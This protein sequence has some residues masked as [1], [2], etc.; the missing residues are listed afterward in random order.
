MRILFLT[1]RFPYPPDRGDRLRAY[2]FIERLSRQHHIHLISFISQQFEIEYIKEIKPFCED[3]QTILLPKYRSILHVGTNFWKPLPLQAIY[4]LSRDMKQLVRTNLH[5]I[6][7]DLAYSHLFRMAP[8]LE[9]EQNIYRIVD[10]T[11]VI[12]REITRSMP[13]RNIL[14]NLLYRVELP[15][16]KK[17][18]SYVGKNFEE[19]W[20]ISKADQSSLKQICP[21]ANIAIVPNGVNNQEF[22]PLG[23]PN[24]SPRII[25]SG[26]FGVFH[27]IDAANVLAKEIIPLVRN[28]IPGCSLMLVGSNPAS[29]VQ[30]L[31][32]LPG[33]CVTGYVP[34]LNEYLNRAAIF[35]APLRF[36]AG[37]QNK[38]LEAMA[39]AKPVITSSIVNEGLGA[40]PGE[41]IIIADTPQ[42]IANQIIS[43]LKDPIRAEHIGKSGH[44]F[45]TSRYSWDHV[46]ERVN[47][48]E[49]KLIR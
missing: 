44:H 19:I 31:S 27:N 35:V 38:V 9:D 4:Y 47:Q 32:A 40:I 36:A 39:A 8:Y 20:L 23:Y 29:E 24:T 14:S 12:S 17:Y 16:I 21:Q 33:V 26:H 7:F 45:V 10:L 28:K 46:L 18:E 6:K 34:N 42:D 13:Y 5:K 30:R 3:I 37:I 2:H 25:F 22:Y 48:I 43:L 49:P 11:D 1:A 41:Q 15:R